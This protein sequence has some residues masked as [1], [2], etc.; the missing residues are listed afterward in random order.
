MAG[1]GDE[2]RKFSREIDRQA[3]EKKK[4]KY[5]DERKRHP[6]FYLKRNLKNKLRSALKQEEDYTPGHATL[7]MRRDTLLTPGHI[8][9]AI[10]AKQ[11][12]GHQVTALEKAL[13]DGYRVARSRDSDRYAVCFGETALADILSAREERDGTVLILLSPPLP[14]LEA[15]I[16]A[17]EKFSRDMRQN[18]AWERGGVVKLKG[19]TYQVQKIEPVPARQACLYTLV[20]FKMKEPEVKRKKGVK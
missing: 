18:L 5:E 6:L 4:K 10:E 2:I 8:G 9:D 16:P 17:L 15:R 1:L 20:P 19:K 7:A 14:P 13:V 3:Q 11:A 12:L